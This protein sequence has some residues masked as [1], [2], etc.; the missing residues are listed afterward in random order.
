MKISSAPVS[1]QTHVRPAQVR[2]MIRCC[3][4]LQ[5][6]FNRLADAT[7][8]NLGHFQDISKEPDWKAVALQWPQQP[9]VREFKE[10]ALNNHFVCANWKAFDEL[11]GEAH[12][13]REE[14]LTA[15]SLVPVDAGFMWL[16]RFIH[17]VVTWEGQTRNSVSPSLQVAANNSGWMIIARLL[18]RELDQAEEVLLEDSNDGG[19]SWDGG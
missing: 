4:D 1:Y 9:A 13:S 19:R 12:R 7:T 6:T 14:L 2:D 3:E 15:R 5:Q 11:Q 10:A 18:Q 8:K 16:R 17:S